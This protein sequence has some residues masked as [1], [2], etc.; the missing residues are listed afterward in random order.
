MVIRVFKTQLIC[1]VGLKF[2]SFKNIV[3]VKNRVF[4]QIRGFLQNW[5][6]RGTYLQPVP[7]QYRYCWGRR[8]PLHA[9]ARWPPPI[10]R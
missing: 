8:Q 1:Q 9:V 2:L 10:D 6:C 7:K 5:N 3:L 4:I